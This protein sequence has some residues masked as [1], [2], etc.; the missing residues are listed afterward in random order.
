MTSSALPSQQIATDNLKLDPRYK[1]L[2]LQMKRD[3]QSR[4]ALIEV[5][6]K[7]HES[8]GYLED[9]V[10]IYIA[11]GLKLPILKTML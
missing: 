2:D 6:H 3:R 10:L 11:R 8:F 5:L 1:S 4:D 9:D 7:A